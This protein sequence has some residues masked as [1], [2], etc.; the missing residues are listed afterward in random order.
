MAV[1]FLFV[2]ISY[3][4]SVRFK[5]CVKFIQNNVN[6]TINMESSDFDYNLP[7]YHFIAESL[8]YTPKK[9]NNGRSNLSAQADSLC[10]APGA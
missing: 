10:S 6:N 9:N 2:F 4:F 1:K 8:L 5:I 7:I 3:S